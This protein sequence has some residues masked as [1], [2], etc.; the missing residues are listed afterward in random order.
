MMSE[1]K[2]RELLKEYDDRFFSF[3]E[4]EDLPPEEKRSYDRI[5][6]MCDMMNTILNYEG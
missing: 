1:S 6:G 3:G 2:L 5:S 4:Y